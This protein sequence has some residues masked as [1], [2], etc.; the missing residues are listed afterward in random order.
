ML[1][2]H[3]GETR[4]ALEL[5]DTRPCVQ[6]ILESKEHEQALLWRTELLQLDLDDSCDS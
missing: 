6:E 4:L 1:Q 2:V 3:Q 5:E